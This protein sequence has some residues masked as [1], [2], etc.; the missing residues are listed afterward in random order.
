MT[1]LLESGIVR[2]PF[3]EVTKGSIQISE[4]LLERNRRNLIEPGCL[5][6]LFE[7]NAPSILRAKAT[8]FYGA[9]R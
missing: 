8:G 2:T 1:L 7:R 6:P 4:G 9:V 5:F 3:K